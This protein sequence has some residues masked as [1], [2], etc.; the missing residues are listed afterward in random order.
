MK[1]VAFVVLV[2]FFG[3]CDFKKVDESEVSNT[4][5]AMKCGPGK[6][7]AAMMGT[8][9][10]LV[11]KKKNVLENMADDDERRDCVEK[12]KTTQEVQE[13]IGDEDTKS[14]TMK[15]GGGMKC[16]AGKCGAAMMDKEEKKPAMKCG[17]GK[18]GSSMK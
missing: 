14:T 5:P 12:A 17:A 18:C 2:L 10:K 1:Y 16:G 8:S 11:A 3:G 4:T 15:C 13:C 7:G 9:T 6:C